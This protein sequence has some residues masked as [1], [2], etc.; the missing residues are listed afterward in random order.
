MSC[1]YPGNK[2]KAAHLCFTVGSVTN[3]WYAILSRD[4]ISTLRQGNTN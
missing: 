2:L 3:Y 4:T 1:R